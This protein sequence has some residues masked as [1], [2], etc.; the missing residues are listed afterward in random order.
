MSEP[1]S[2]EQAALPA[3]THTLTMEN[4]SRLTVTGVTRVIRRERRHF[5]DADGGPDH[6]RPG[7]PGQ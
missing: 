5:A 1:I 4:R 6:R 3:R 2:Q 7:N